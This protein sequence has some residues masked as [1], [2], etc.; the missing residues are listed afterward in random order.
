[1]MTI[2]PPLSASFIVKLGFNDKY[3]SLSFSSDVKFDCWELGFLSGSVT[4]FWTVD[5][6]LCKFKGVSW[7]EFK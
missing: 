3:L 7:F 5:I 4:S 2:L 6:Y 1:M